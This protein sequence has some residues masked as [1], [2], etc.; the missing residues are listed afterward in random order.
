MGFVLLSLLLHFVDAVLHGLADLLQINVDLILAIVALS[1][2]QL[3]FLF[4]FDHL[5]C[6]L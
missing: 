4:D 2:V 1:F 5:L 6:E 3:V